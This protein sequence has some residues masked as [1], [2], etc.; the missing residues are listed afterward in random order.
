MV[1]WD[2]LQH[3]PNRPCLVLRAV[4]SHF[5]TRNAVSLPWRDKS[6]YCTL[7]LEHWQRLGPAANPSIRRRR[8]CLWSTD[9][10]ITLSHPKSKMRC[11]ASS[12]SLIRSLAG[13]CS[14]FPTLGAAPWECK[15]KLE[16]AA[17]AISV[18]R[19]KSCLGALRSPGFSRTLTSSFWLFMQVVR[20]SNRG[21]K[22]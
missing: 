21:K 9:T 2:P 16:A 7:Q 5:D 8:G 13:T 10:T 14:A 4:Q 19:R 22:C 17:V 12:I 1:P 3:V 20:S 15:E 11:K 6:L 18:E